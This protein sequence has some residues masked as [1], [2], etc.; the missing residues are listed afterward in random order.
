MQGLIG[1]VDVKLKDPIK[2]VQSKLLKIGIDNI[3][4][5][6]ATGI[7]ADIMGEVDF[8]FERKVKNRKDKVILNLN[9]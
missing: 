8:S 7:I 5:R 1:R 4:D 2:M 9:S 3:S 6:Q